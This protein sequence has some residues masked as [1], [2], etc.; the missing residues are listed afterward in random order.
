M[1]HI[2]SSYTTYYNVKRKRAGHLLQ[3]RYK[4]IIVDA[5]EYV[6]ELSRYIHLNPVRVGS[7]KKPE[8]YRWSSCSS[9]TGEAT[10]PTWLKT[11]FIISCFGSGKS[12]A[13]KKYRQFVHDLLGQEYDSPLTA[14]VASTILGHE[15]FVCEMQERHLSGKGKDRDLPA[16][17]EL[18]IRPLP[19]KILEAVE[20]ACPADERLCRKMAVYFCHRYSGAKLKDIGNL[21]EL[22][23]SGVTQ[24]SSRFRRDLE[25]NE[26]LK[27]LSQRIA[28]S[29]GLSIV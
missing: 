11:D 3:G 17:R 12:A 7:V 15:E 9:Y 18:A 8:D 14:T 1:K 25:A 10:A 24:A 21:F 4:A 16:L 2:N 22:S 5:D 27:A 28:T 19:E 29:L 13:Q 26:Q 6:T 20:M 23:E